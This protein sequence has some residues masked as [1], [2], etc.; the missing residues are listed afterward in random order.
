[1]RTLLE[2]IDLYLLNESLGRINLKI[3]NKMIDEIEKLKNIKLSDKERAKIYVSLLK[4]ERGDK[5]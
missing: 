3:I 5:K 2:K 1:M 4:K